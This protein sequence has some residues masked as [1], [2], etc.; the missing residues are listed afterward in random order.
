EAGRAGADD[1]HLLPGAV[2]RRRRRHPALVPRA[3]DDGR[4]DRLDGDRIVVDAEHARALAW[5]GTQLAGELREVV[6]RVQPLDRG[7]PA[8]PVDQVVP[9]GNQ[10]PERAA[11]VTERDAAVHAARALHLELAGRIR[12]VDLAPALHALV[13]R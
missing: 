13:H 5:R 10:I 7:P 12:Q 9:V 6:G 4:L 3:V 8:I 11:L 2:L 1:G